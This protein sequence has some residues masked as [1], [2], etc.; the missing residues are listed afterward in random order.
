MPRRA[1]VL[2]AVL[3]VGAVGAAVATCGND[4]KP[5]DKATATTTTAVT[6]A[7]TTVAT[8][9]PSGPA[10]TPDAAALGLFNAWK[11]NDQNDA[12]HYA[13][14]QAITKMFKQPYTDGSVK[15]TNQGCQPEGGQFNCAWSYEGGA[16]T[17]TVE[18]W[19]GGGFVVD[20]VTYIAD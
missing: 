4:D 5:S 8:T 6:T 14:P 15:Y 19:P 17:M 11:K 12:S 3:A 10:S 16:L 18:A 1:S 2:F 20:S 13:K 9:V 7:P